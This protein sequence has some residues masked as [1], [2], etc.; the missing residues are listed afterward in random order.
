MSLRKRVES[1]E[2]RRKRDVHFLILRGDC[3][4]ERAV[5]EEQERLGPRVEVR[6]IR[7]REVDPAELAADMRGQP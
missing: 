1:L 4:V 2:R 6:V 5:A 7:I 3:D